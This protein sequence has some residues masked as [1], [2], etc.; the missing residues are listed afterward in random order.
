MGKGNLFNKKKWKFDAIHIR[1]DYYT[2]LYNNERQ[3]KKVVHKNL[4]RVAIE[5]IYPDKKMYRQYV[6]EQLQNKWF[7]TSIGD[8]SLSRNKN[9]EFYAF[10]ERFVSDSVF[11]REHVADPLGFVTYDEDN[12][13]ERI[14]GV[15]D[16]DQWFVFRPDLP[17]GVLTNI[18]YGQPFNDSNKRIFVMHGLSN[19]MQSVFRFQKIKGSWYLNSFEN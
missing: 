1:G 4:S 15:V 6:F 10:Y 3:L 18:D 9:A 14:D 2:V 7:L 17:K 8:Y 13:Y 12:H 16:I 5:L 19:G 11:Q